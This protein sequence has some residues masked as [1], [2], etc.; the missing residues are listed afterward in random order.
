MQSIRNKTK[1]NNGEENEQRY[2]SLKT[3]MLQARNRSFDYHMMS[4]PQ[5]IF[6][7]NSPQDR[8]SSIV[9]WKT[10]KQAAKD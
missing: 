8:E 7:E 3:S 1:T 4:E 10:T 2:S 6:D 5:R 9:R